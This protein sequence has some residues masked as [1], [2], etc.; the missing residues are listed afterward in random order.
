MEILAVVASWTVAVVCRNVAPRTWL[1]GVCHREVNTSS[2]AE[3]LS[4]GAKVYY[5]GS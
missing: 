2:I 5:P 1:T 4:A 3:R